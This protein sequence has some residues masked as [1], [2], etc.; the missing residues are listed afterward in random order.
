LWLLRRPSLRGLFG[1]SIFLDCP[2]ALRLKRRLAR[3]M[4]SRGGESASVRR[5]FRRIVQPMHARYVEPQARRAMVRLRTPVSAAQVRRLAAE[6]QKMKTGY[7]G[8]GSPRAR[9]PG[10]V[11][12]FPPNF[13]HQIVQEGYSL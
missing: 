7:S 8:I 11:P 2:A 10:S 13:L 5:Q 12:F 6:L 4:L 9:R 3:D 1:L